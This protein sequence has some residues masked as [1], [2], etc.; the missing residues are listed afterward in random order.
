MSKKLLFAALVG[1]SVVALDAGGWAQAAPVARAAPRASAA[2]LKV[3][4]AEMEALK[5]RL[6]QQSAA[7]TQEAEQLQKVQADLAATQA[8]LAAAKA[9]A[10]RAA[11]TARAEQ[12]QILTLPAQV[13]SQVDTAVAAA[14]PKE[15]GKLHYRGVTVTLGGFSELAGMRPP[16]SPH[17]SPR[18]PSPMTGPRTPARPD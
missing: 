14:K 8:Q 2:D 13:R 6:D 5:A 17:P 10:D 11:Q 15:D 1:G 12:Q 18:F 16:T 3:L 7:S 9:A 4:Q